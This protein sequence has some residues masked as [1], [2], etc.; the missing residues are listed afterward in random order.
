MPS[1]QQIR[2]AAFR[3]LPTVAIGSAPHGAGLTQTETILWAATGTDRALPD[4][5]LLGQ[6]VHLR[7][8]FVHAAWDYGDHTSATTT[9]PGKAYDDASDP[10]DTAQCAGYSGHTYTTT[11]TVTV[12]LAIT[13]TAQYQLAG[14]AWQDI[15]EA[16]TGPA[17]TSTLTIRQARGVLV[18]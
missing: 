5:T 11:G 12:T 4:V 6:L 17:A 3:L 14:G 18:H 15:P 9:S 13:W 10:C 7:I 8:H 2:D 1:V 16:I